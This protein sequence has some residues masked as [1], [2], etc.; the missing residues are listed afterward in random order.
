MSAWRITERWARDQEKIELEE[1]RLHEEG[2]CNEVTCLD[3][4]T[5][6]E[7]ADEDQD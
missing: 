3:C 5:E 1:R 6:K 2:M 4:I 7:M